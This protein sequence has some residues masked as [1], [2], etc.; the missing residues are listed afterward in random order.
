MRSGGH[1]SV[2]NRYLNHDDTKE[3]Q[4]GYAVLGTLKGEAVVARLA[5][6]L[7]RVKA[8]RFPPALHLDV[9]NAAKRQG[10]PELMTLLKGMP[11]P[12]AEAAMLSGGDAIR[13]RNLLL[14]HSGG[15]CLVCHTFDGVG[16]DVGPALDRV[17]GRTRESLLQ[18][19]IR[20]DADLSEGYGHVS[21]TLKDGR[22][23]AGFLVEEDQVRL[24]LR[25][26]DGKVQNV[27]L[28]D[29]VEREPARSMMPSMLPILSRQEIRDVVEFLATQD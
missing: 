23:L 19:L 24:G 18:S 13:G 5:G 14:G 4:A 7:K 22:K 1:P 3:Q 21:V 16:R 28:V 27:L 12:I 15:Q 17:G 2:L 6:D 8:G 25:T 11:E 10:A 9:L 20:P 26:T 29:V